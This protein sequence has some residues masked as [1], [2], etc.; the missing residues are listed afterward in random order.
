MSCAKPN[1]SSRPTRPPHALAPCR[2]ARQLFRFTEPGFVRVAVGARLLHRL[3]A[4]LL[5]LLGRGLPV[6][7]ACYGAHCAL[8]GKVLGEVLKRVEDS[9]SRLFGRLTSAAPLTYWAWPP[10]RDGFCSLEDIV[11]VVVAYSIKFSCGFVW[12]GFKWFN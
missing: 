10:T 4:R 6:V 3:D 8:G 7:G 12:K 9:F 11:L 2:F 1:S 5:V